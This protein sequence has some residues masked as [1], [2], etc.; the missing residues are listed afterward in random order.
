MIQSVLKGSFLLGGFLALFSAQSS[1]QQIHA[2]SVREALALAK[3][4]NVQ[5]K[6]ALINLQ[7]QEQNNKAITARALPNISGTAGSTWF[8][9]TPV[10]IVPGELF[11]GQ[12]GSEIAVNFT[13][14][15]NA[16]AGV[17]LSQALFDGQVFVGLK[18]RQSA[19]DYYQKAVDLTVEAISVNIY[20]VYYQLVVSKTQIQQLDANIDRA[21]KL[22]HDTKVMLD[23]GFQEQLDV[24]KA[25]VQLANL[26][27]TKLNTQTSAANGY[28]VLKYLT[29][30]PIRDSVVLSDHFSEDDLNNGMNLDTSYRYEER[31]DFQSLQVSKK[32][33]DYNVRA[34]KALYYPTVNLAGSY[35]KNAYNNTYDFLS[36][37]GSWYSNSYLA[38]NI[39]IPIFNGFARNANLKIARLQSLQTDN[40]IE[41]LKLSID[42]EVYQARNNFNTAILTVNNQKK[43]TALA[44]SVYNQTKKKYESG[45]ASNTDVTNAQTDL[46]QAQSN[47]INALYMAV[48]ARVDYL[49][50]VGKI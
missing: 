9:Q 35:Q 14:K 42:N 50:A 25:T 11:G 8:F 41:N 16:N 38:V 39:N 6:N 20:K 10:T 17:M 47:Y 24:D 40:Q 15:Y 28:L 12:P 37:G 7:I 44:E 27:T 48:I 21:A 31:Y 2:L 36:K 5:V 22:L 3:K 49:K 34:Y 32:L 30:L 29:G 1:A 18:A 19:I 45:L 4:N 13:P 26:E 46:I 33:N 43:N 23:N